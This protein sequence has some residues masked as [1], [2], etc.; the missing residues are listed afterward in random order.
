MDQCFYGP[1]MGVVSDCLRGMLIASPGMELIAADFAAIEA[2]VLAWLAGQRD[3]I[4]LFATGGDAYRHMAAEIYGRSADAIVK[5]SVE[6]QLGKQAVLGCGYGLATQIPG[7]LCQ[8]RH[9]N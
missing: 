6:R 8:G 1:P 4:R 9:P 7:D 3:L 2:R 5:G